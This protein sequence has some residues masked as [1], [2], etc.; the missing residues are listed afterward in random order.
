MKLN[1]D[2]KIY[3]WLD[4]Q[5][6]EKAMPDR[7]PPEGWMGVADGKEFREVVEEAISKDI[8]LGGLNFDN[9]LGD[10]KEEGYKIAEWIILEHPEWFKGDEILVAHTKDVARKP[11]IEGHFRDIQTYRDRLLEMKEERG[12]KLG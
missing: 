9:D 5:W 10:G 6:M 7:W 1:K 4:D 12:G 3:L 8:L 11:D 2:G